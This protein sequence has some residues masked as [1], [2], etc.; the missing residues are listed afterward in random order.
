MRYLLASRAIVVNTI[1][2]DAKIKEVKNKIPNITNLATTSTLSVVE[3]QN[4]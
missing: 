2:L 4:T 3:K 1:A